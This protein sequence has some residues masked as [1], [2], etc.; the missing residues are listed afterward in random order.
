[1]NIQ[2]RL[3][4]LERASN[5]DS[6]F[7]TCPCE[8]QTRVILPDLLETE[9]ARKMR[10]AEYQKPES[11]EGCGKLIERRIIIVEAF[12]APESVVSDCRM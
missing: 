7:C 4:K 9:D 3:E 10:I 12:E 11:C 8:T 6:A 2:N 5:I 1:M